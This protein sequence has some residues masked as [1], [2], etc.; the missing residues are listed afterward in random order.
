MRCWL[1]AGGAIA[2]LA[3]GAAPARADVV[4]YPLPGTRTASK[5]T[6]ISFRGAAPA[7]IGAVPIT[8]SRSGRHGGRL[9][10]PS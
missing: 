9:G 1:A 4:A 2:L 8:G 7:A 5:D 6:Q 10:N 3:A